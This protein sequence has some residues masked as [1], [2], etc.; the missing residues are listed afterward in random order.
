MARTRRIYT[1]EFK[2]QAVKLVTEQ[3]YSTAEAARSLGICD[4]LI[5]NWKRALHDRGAHAFPGWGSPRRVDRGYRWSA[6]D[7]PATRR[8]FRS[9]TTVRHSLA[10]PPPLFAT[11]VPKR[12]E[13]LSMTQPHCGTWQ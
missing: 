4:N 11:R 2:A 5:R 10:G 9:S 12:S 8:E 7:Q 13:R 1:P 6:T 3:G